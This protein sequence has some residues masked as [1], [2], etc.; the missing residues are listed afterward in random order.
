MMAFLRRLALIAFPHFLLCAFC[1][2]YVKGVSGGDIG[3]RFFCML[4]LCIYVWIVSMLI[5]F[6]AKNKKSY[7]LAL[8]F[9]VFLEISMDFFL[10]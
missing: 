8:L 10:F 5:I 7:F 2:L 1:Y 9:L 6:R 3:F 4:S